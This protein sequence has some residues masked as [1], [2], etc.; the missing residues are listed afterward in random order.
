[1]KTDGFS[2]KLTV[3]LG[4]ISIDLPQ[5]LLENLQAEIKQ[6]HKLKISKI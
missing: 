5:N 6:L 1:M 2:F 4:I 3:P